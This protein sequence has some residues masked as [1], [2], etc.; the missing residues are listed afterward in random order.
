M[1]ANDGTPSP[2]VTVAIV[3]ICSAAHLTRCLDA[4][5]SQEGAPPFDIVV[6]YD[7]RL[8][9][10]ASLGSRYPR[11]RLVATESEHTP[12]ELAARA[13]REAK[14]DLVLLTEDHCIPRPD[15][16]RRLCAAL[17]PGRAAV[18][19]LVEPDS[20]T[21][22]ADWAFW[23]TDFFRYTKPIAAGP[24][25][26]LSVCNVAYRRSQMAQV[27]AVWGRRFLET[28]V[29]DALRQRFGTLWMV[30]EAEVRTKRS[31]RLADAVY[32][33]YGFGRLFGY[34]RIQLTGPVHRAYYATTAP[35]LPLLLMTRMARKALRSRACTLQYCRALPMLTL[36]VLA[37][38]WG[39]W[40]GYLTGRGPRS[41]AAAPDA[42]SSFPG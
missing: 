42:A 8:D 33:R 21:S 39:E 7:F 5:T 36:L 4:L 30:P 11:V 16:V 28:A 17:V 6:A 41:L 20:V 32:E 2:S 1:I 37:W 9:D 10:I 34:T 40:L 24:S 26:S 31:V 23:F 3:G 18:G 22:T 12:V 38:S 14:G 13:I 29:H 25:A 35:A 15:W 19:G 27:E